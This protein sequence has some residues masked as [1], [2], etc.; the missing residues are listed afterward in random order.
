MNSVTNKVT[1]TKCMKP[2]NNFVYECRICGSGFSDVQELFAHSEK[3]DT[4]ASNDIPVAEKSKSLYSCVECPAK[5]ELYLDLQAHAKLHSDDS[6]SILS[7][8]SGNAEFDDDFVDENSDGSCFGVRRKGN[9][10][11]SSDVLER[12]QNRLYP[13]VK[14]ENDVLNLEDS[15]LV[16]NLDC[17]DYETH[18]VTQDDEYKPDLVSD[19]E[20]NANSDLDED[21]VP[22]VP[23]KRQCQHCSQS[24]SCSSSLKR[25]MLIHSGERPYVCNICSRT[26]TQSST[27]KKHLRRIHK[28]AWEQL[29]R[30]GG[31]ENNAFRF[32]RDEVTENSN[33]ED[34]KVENRNDLNALVEYDA[35]TIADI[36]DPESLKC[37]YCQ[38]QFSTVE[39]L[40]A[41]EKT[42]TSD[43]PHSCPSCGRC[44]GYKSHLNRHMLIHTGEKPFKCKICKL[45][46]R[47]KVSLNAHMRSHHSRVPA[48][49]HM[50]SSDDNTQK[51][52]RIGRADDA[53]FECELC[54]KSF[55]VYSAYARHRTF[56]LSN[57]LK[58]LTCG[59]KFSRASILRQHTRIHTGERPFFCGVCGNKFRF[60]IQLKRHMKSMHPQENFQVD[61]DPDYADGIVA[62]GDI[63]CNESDDI[64]DVI[65]IDDSRNNEVNAAVENEP[66][67]DQVDAEYFEK[68]VSQKRLGV[69]VQ[70][71]PKLV[72]ELNALEKTNQN[73]FNDED[74][75]AL[76]SDDDGG[77][78]QDNADSVLAH[79]DSRR[80]KKSKAREPGLGSETL[81]KL[82]VSMNTGKCSYCTKTFFS[83]SDMRRHLRTH[84][85]EKPFECNLCEGRFTQK[86]SLVEH[87]RTHTG[88]RPHKCD[89]CGMRFRYRSHLARHVKRNLHFPEIAPVFDEN[90]SMST[91]SCMACSEEFYNLDRLRQ[92]LETVHRIGEDVNIAEMEIDAKSGSVRVCENMSPVMRSIKQE[93]LEDF[94][95]GAIKLSTAE[96]FTCEV[97]KSGFAEY[98]TWIAHLNTHS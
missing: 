52:N 62:S 78:T 40:T 1:P 13:N 67:D 61:G 93:A 3:H 34:R 89:V 48:Y 18:L 95:S 25:H 8:I 37:R 59:K 98:E 44:F 4:D 46:F 71:D 2:R 41:H 68:L 83:R 84:T 42:H 10:I 32:H 56:H 51:R 28:S 11:S 58:C 19:V 73:H 87:Q 53:D 31:L 65:A 96:L 49:H 27:L 91:F 16:E 69:L 15:R 7:K 90:Q 30:D 6:N 75:T 72:E 64:V 20:E 66:I 17:E 54:K 81:I 9:L 33:S 74:I 94:E 47:Q 79:S 63:V 82:G 88:E 85:G 97:C 77:Y 60:S 45:R 26:F 24:F 29:Q 70:L 57:P 50:M 43:R 22:V 38:V 86:K 5:F 76:A 14:H 35:P 92:H 55:P 39:F 21:Y 23:R 80:P 12:L 36:A